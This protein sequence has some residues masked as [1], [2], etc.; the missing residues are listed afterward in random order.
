MLKTRWWDMPGNKC[1][2]GRWEDAEK[3]SQASL[4]VANQ[5]YANGL[6]NFI[7]VLDAERSMYQTQ[8]QLVQ[9]ERARSINL[10]SLYKALGGGW[11]TVPKLANAR[12]D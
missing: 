11:K 2:F 8:D 12:G 9:S 6:A 5:L 10:I 7:N 3:S 1:A 4:Q